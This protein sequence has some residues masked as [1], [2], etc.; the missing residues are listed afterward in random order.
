MAKTK[1]S[2]QNAN[3]ALRIIRKLGTSDDEIEVQS[4]LV[5]LDLIADKSEEVLARIAEMAP[6]MATES[7]GRRS[8]LTAWEANARA[9]LGQH[10]EATA[11]LESIGG[12]PTWPHFQIR[13]DLARA[14]AWRRA[15]HP[16]RSAQISEQALTMSTD[17]GYRYFQLLAHHEL[18]KVAAAPEERDRHKRQSVSLARSLAANL[19][20]EDGRAFTSRPWGGA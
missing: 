6:L 16:E 1:E 4:L 10:D 2:R 17:K 8:Q 15:G 18:A 9:R 5:R 20:P 7:E 3:E 12:A 13:I 11:L 14:R 19:S